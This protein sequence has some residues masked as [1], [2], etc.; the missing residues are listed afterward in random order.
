MNPHRWLALSLGVALLSACAPFTSPPPPT[1]VGSRSAL[2]GRLQN[3]GPAAGASCAEVHLALAE[4]Y[5]RSDPITQ[6]ALDNA[7]SELALAAQNPE[8]GRETAPLYRSVQGW[9]D[10][11]RKR[12]DAEA[13]LDAAQTQLHDAK[14]Q[15]DTT[16][17]RLARLESLLR[18]KA[19]DTLQNLQ[20]RQP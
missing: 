19:Q 14:A 1:P 7:A 13:Q 15:L 3:C 8:V 10:A 2:L 18:H 16:N 5:L 6:T 11:L 20:P 17:A 12:R 4:S 9:R